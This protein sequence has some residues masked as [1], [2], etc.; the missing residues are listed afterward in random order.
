MRFH[1]L[2]SV[3]VSKFRED[4]YLGNRVVPPYDSPKGMF[5]FE[6]QYYR[7][8]IKKDD[9]ACLKRSIVLNFDATGG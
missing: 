4:E 1:I 6:A 5:V 2:E 9:S 8:R 3:K 7:L